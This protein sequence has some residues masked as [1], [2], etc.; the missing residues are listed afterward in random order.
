MLL[1]CITSSLRVDVIL[2]GGGA[3]RT[4]LPL[5]DSRIGTEEIHIIVISPKKWK[6]SLRF[7][8]SVQRHVTVE[9]FS[10]AAERLVHKLGDIFTTDG[11]KQTLFKCF[12][13]ERRR[14]HEDIR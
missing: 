2:Y 6:L 1:G 3:G 14:K 12:L 8:S 11:Y 5:S 10:L 7:K 9:T 4:K 13:K